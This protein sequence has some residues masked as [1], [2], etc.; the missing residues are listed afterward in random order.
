[1]H[2]HRCS[3]VRRKFPKGRNKV[4]HNRHNFMGSA[5]GTTIQRRPGGM[6]RKNFAKLHLKMRI[7]VHSGSKF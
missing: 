6:P 5:E 3:G 1:M 7:L 2:I 4:S